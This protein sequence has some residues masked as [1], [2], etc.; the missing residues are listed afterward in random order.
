[1]GSV[2]NIGNDTKGLKH[3]LHFYQI[4]LHAFLFYPLPLLFAG[5]DSVVNITA[6]EEQRLYDQKNQYITILLKGFSSAMFTTL[7]SISLYAQCFHQSGAVYL[8]T[9]RQRRCSV[10]CPVTLNICFKRVCSY[11]V[12]YMYDFDHEAIL[13]ILAV[14]IKGRI[15]ITVDA[16]NTLVIDLC[17]GPELKDV[18]VTFEESISYLRYDYYP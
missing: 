18:S 15:S 7:Y 6:Y 5:L 17:C 3:K 1:M 9:Q 12:L 11:G 8:C 10:C 13:N 4:F 14:R 2:Q 16:K